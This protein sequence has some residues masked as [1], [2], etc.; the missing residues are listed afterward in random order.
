M[1]ISCEGLNNKLWGKPAVSQGEKVTDFATSSG[2]AE[3]TAFNLQPPIKR[4][5]KIRSKWGCAGRSFGPSAAAKLSNM[6]AESWKK[7][8]RPLPG[9][10]TYQTIL[11][12]HGILEESKFTPLC[13]NK[14]EKCTYFVYEQD[15]IFIIIF[16]FQFYIF[17][18]LYWQ[19]NFGNS[20]KRLSF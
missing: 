18:Q 12:P 17:Q 8:S 19:D 3:R 15:I 4:R 1:W 10:A 9:M 6:P 20:Y 5:R 11:L 14:S 13:M 7:S 16:Y 2:R